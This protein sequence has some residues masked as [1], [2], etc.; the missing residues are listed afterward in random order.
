MTESVEAHRAQP[1]AGVLLVNLGT[2]DAP[3][4]PAI[5]RYLREFLSDRRIVDLPRALWWPILNGIILPLR[6]RRLAK[7]YASV[8]LEEGAPLL[9]HTREL[10]EGVAR[11]LVTAGLDG[12]PVFHAMRYGNPSIASAIA[13][14]RE[15]SVRRLVV[16]PLYPQYSGTTTASVMDGVFSALSAERWMPELR[17]V[18]AYHDDPAFIHALA[19]SVQAHWLQ[20]G[21][22]DHLLMSFHGIPQRYFDA[23]DPYHCHCH[24]TARLLAEALALGEDDYSV[25]FQSRFGREPWLQPYADER[26]DALAARGV[27]QLDAICPGF[28]A[29]CLETLEEMAQQYAEQFQAAGGK[30]LRYVPALN[31][32]PEHC[33]TIAQLAARQLAGWQPT[34]IDSELIAERVQRLPTSGG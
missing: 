28:A 18:H 20:H 5:R 12:V 32:Q 23:G 3:T 17:S 31:A 8:W 24:K 21:R 19:D 34:A 9:V 1:R 4:A 13:Q 16:I 11:E 2:P 6:P 22:G 27:R 25:C 33:A 10:A 26:I 30:A 29:D 15:Q 7:S 14:A